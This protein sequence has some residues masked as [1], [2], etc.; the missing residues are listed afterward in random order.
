MLTNRPVK[1]YEWWRPEGCDY[2]TLF[3]K[4]LIGRGKFHQ[5]GTYCTEN[6]VN[7]GTATSCI[8]EMSDGNLLNIEVELVQFD[9][10]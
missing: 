7:I 6:E 8:I 5:F 1:V 4:K 9:D 10:V 3:E 2:R